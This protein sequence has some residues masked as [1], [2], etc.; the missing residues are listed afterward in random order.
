VYQYAMTLLFLAAMPGGE[1]LRYARWWF[2]ALYLHSG[3]SK[4]DASF[5]DELGLVILRAAVT[6]LGFDPARWEPRWRTAAVH[7]K[8]AA[9]ITLAW[10][11]AV[12]T[13]RRLGRVGAV[14]LHAALIAILGPARLAQ[15]TIVLVWNAA[16][17]VEVWFAFGPDLEGHP[18]AGW[19]AWPVKAVF[20]AGVLMPIGE[21]WGVWDAWPSHALYA[22]HVGRVS[23]LV[24]ES[25]LGHYPAAL[26][27]HL[28]DVG[29]GPWLR[30]DLNG[31]SRAVRG[32]PVYPQNRAGVGLAE[33]LAS[34]Y[35]G[36]FPVRVVAFGAAERWTGRRRRD[37][38][39]GL[40]EIRGLGDRFRCNAHPW[41]GDRGER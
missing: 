40:V 16:V 39:V 11:L 38:A 22:S 36:P 5:C 18:A 21:R 12:P 8:P 3:L 1:G 26:R 19:R 15:S 14:A 37:E 29:E 20:W 34:G 31:W 9:E 10:A 28:E 17:M 25:A 7:A 35:G 41:P 33:A 13:A 24:H 27:G 4:L 6:P 23:V 2:V 30:V 32:T